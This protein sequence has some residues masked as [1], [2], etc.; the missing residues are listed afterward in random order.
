MRRP[1]DPSARTSLDGVAGR[2]D[3]TTAVRRRGNERPPPSRLCRQRSGISGSE[4]TVVVR[5]DWKVLIVDASRLPDECGTPPTSFDEL[6]RTVAAHSRDGG[7]EIKISV[8]NRVASDRCCT[9]CG[10]M[11]PRTAGC[12]IAQA[13]SR[14]RRRP[15][16]GVAGVTTRVLVE[17]VGADDVN[18][19]GKSIGRASPEATWSTD[20]GLLTVLGSA[21]RGE[22]IEPSRRVRAAFR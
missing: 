3:C 1:T 19:V 14:V 12:G 13:T 17:Q 9:R 8:G 6:D 2:P 7:T 15:E 5:K 16:L 21:E 10:A 20:E 11:W 22:S 4:G 18:R